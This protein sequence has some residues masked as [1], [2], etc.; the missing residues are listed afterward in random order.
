MRF[1]IFSIINQIMPHP[2][3]IYHPKY[4]W[5]DEEGKR[6]Q[7]GHY[8]I[9]DSMAPL[10]NHMDG[11]T[12]DSKSEYRK[13]IEG[14]ETPD[15]KRYRIVGNDYKGKMELPKSPKITYEQ[16]RDAKEY[17]QSIASDP[18]KLRAWRQQQDERRAEYRNYGLGDDE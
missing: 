8:V 3:K 2:K 9:N 12:Y 5:F 15:G 11:K 10:L 13:A 16:F 1:F 7:G 6:P 17:A 4:G 14:T 18:S